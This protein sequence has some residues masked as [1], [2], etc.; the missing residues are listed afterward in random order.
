[1]A[2][3][4]ALAAG[5]VATVM[6]FASRSVTGDP[7]LVVDDVSTPT[8]APQ[9]PEPRPWRAPAAGR[10]AGLPAAPLQ[11]RIA[12]S[13]VWTG[14]GLFVWGGFSQDARALQDGAVFDPVAGTWREL[15]PTSMPTTTQPAVMVAGRVLVM[16]PTA[17]A[18][19][20]VQRDQWIDLPPPPLP[21]GMALTDQVVTRGDAAV[22]LAVDAGTAR[23]RLLALDPELGWREV[24]A[25]PVR[26]AA[27]DALLGSSRRLMLLTRPSPDDPVVVHQLARGTRRWRRIAAP[28]GLE[29][30]PVARLTGT[31]RAWRAI[32]LGIPPD[33]G[34][35]Y[36]ARY[37]QG[38][39]RRLPPPPIEARGEIDV[40]EAGPDIVLWKHVEG[41]GVRYDEDL[42][43]WVAL[44]RSPTPRA[45]AH[46]VVW[47]GDGIAT[48][49]G[50]TSIGALY[51]LP[52][53]RGADPPPSPF[54]IE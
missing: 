15:P 33:G 26:V 28:P 20:D 22:V 7:R 43:R 21:E 5:A 54:L 24:P 1:M 42:D 46:P 17:A 12:Q 30:T 18:A 45:V 32:V 11:R 51:R 16:S 38:R 9:A 25:P 35:P 52:P 40:I 53:E 23:S 27:G 48:W 3:A 31:A 39:W 6:L 36:V 19:Y 44:P 37:A 47:T 4:V 13:M 41:G 34:V 2:L 50:L 10:W 49:G 14:R 8:A 29:A